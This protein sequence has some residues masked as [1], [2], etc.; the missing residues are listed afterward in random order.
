MWINQAYLDIV[1]K[2]YVLWYNIFLLPIII[3]SNVC[4]IQ[5]PSGCMRIIKVQAWKISEM[6]GHFGMMLLLNSIPETSKWSQHNSSAYIYIWW[7]SLYIILSMAKCVK[8]RFLMLSYVCMHVCMYVCMHVCMYA[9]M[10]V[11]MH[12]WVYACMH[13]CMYACMHVCMYACMHVC[14]YACMHVC[15]YACM[16]V[17]MYVCMYVC[18]CVC[19]YVCMHSCMCMYVCI[20]LSIY[21]SIYAFISFCLFFIHIHMPNTLI[22]WY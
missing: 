13:V 9:C 5:K 8:H 6:L 11:C 22:R 17:C 2:K 10:Y 3:G 14:M 12:V 16:H 4:T 21:L 18:V 15:M 20:Y 1:R 7:W 19:I